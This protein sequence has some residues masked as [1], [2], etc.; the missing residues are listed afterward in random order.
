MQDVGFS[1]L[2]ILAPHVPH[3]IMPSTGPPF[4]LARVLIVPFLAI[5]ENLNLFFADWVMASSYMDGHLVREAF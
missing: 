1:W 5:C 3:A 2:T 4:L